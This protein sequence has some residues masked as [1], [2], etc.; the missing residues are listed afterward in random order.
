MRAALKKGGVTYQAMGDELG[1]TKG[2]VGHW[3][4][5]K[6][7]PS[8]DQVLRIA[9]RTGYPLPVEG[10][11]RPPDVTIHTQNKGEPDPLVAHSESQIRTTLPSHISWEG[12]RVVHGNSALPQEFVTSIPDGAM[13][14]R[15]GPGTNI[16]FKKADSARPRQVIMVEAAGKRWIRRYA[17]TEAGPEAQAMDTAFPTFREFTVVAVMYMLQVSEV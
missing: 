8:F 6:Y 15:I 5:G 12:L 14:P 2:A 9:A 1:L 13:A 7:R 16:W 4:T 17:E 11:I 3:A 10:L